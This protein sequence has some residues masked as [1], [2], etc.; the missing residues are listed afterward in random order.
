MVLV[1]T[2]LESRERFSHRGQFTLRL[3]G[4]AI[5]PLGE[6]LPTLQNGVNEDHVLVRGVVEVYPLWDLSEHELLV[7]FRNIKLVSLGFITDGVLIPNSTEIK[8]VGDSALIKPYHP[9]SV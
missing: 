2:V 3:I 4:Y 9:I 6:S 5:L 7:W 8:D 1:N